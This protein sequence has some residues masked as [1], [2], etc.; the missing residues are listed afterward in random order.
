MAL[1]G[2]GTGLAFAVL[3]MKEDAG[4]VGVFVD[5]ESPGGVVEV[6]EGSASGFGDHA[7]GFMEDMVAVADGGAEGVSCEAVGVDADE[8]GVGFFLMRMGADVAANE[9]EV[10]FL[11]ADFTFVGDEAEVAVCGGE[12]SLGD[13]IDVALVLQAVADELGDG[14][15]FEAVLVAEVDEIG[16]AG[17]GAVVAHD[18]AD[19]ACRDE[20]GEACEVDGGLGLSGADEDAA[21]A[22][23]EGEDV[24]GTGEVLGGCGGVDGDADGVGAVMGADAGGDAFAGLDTL[25]EGSAEAGGVLLDHGVEAEVVG[26]LLGEGEADESSA[27]AG[28]EVD[29]LGGDE[30]GGEGE[31][32]FVFAVLVID[33][34]DHPAGADLGDGCWD[35]NEGGLGLH[36]NLVSHE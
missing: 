21:L 23:A 35:V 13:A 3:G 30:F 8:D 27:E 15:H 28:H 5:A 25:S 34:D 24:A 20:A 19:D 16:D 22:G 32:A 17:H 14:E 12:G 11:G 6:D 31:V 33:D 4:R 10:A 2:L 1:A 36:D 7:H 18:F 29:G 26:A 9:G